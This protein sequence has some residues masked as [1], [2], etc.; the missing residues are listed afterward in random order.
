MSRPRRTLKSTTKVMEN[1]HDTDNKEM[2]NSQLTKKRKRKRSARYKSS[3]SNNNDQLQLPETNYSHLTTFQAN[4]QANA[5]SKTKKKIINYDASGKRT[6]TCDRCGKSFNNGHALGGH[7]KYCGKAEAAE[8]AADAASAASAADCTMKE[9]EEV[10]DAYSA[11][12]HVGG[13]HRRWHAGK[14]ETPSHQ[15]SPTSITGNINHRFTVHATNRYEW[16]V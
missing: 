4:G 15:H 11:S 16:Y 3:Q 5:T 6:H 10:D 9:E 8:A 12:R 7:K 2:E 1:Q 13:V 14:T